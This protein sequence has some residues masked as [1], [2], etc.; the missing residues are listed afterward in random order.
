MAYELLRDCWY[1]ECSSGNGACTPGLARGSVG[2]PCAMFGTLEHGQHKVIKVNGL[3]TSAADHLLLQVTCNAPVVHW[4]K[5]RGDGWVNQTRPRGH[6]RPTY[7]A[8]PLLPMGMHL[9]QAEVSRLGTSMKTL[10]RER[11]NQS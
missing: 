4:K 9:Q 5:R 2:D 3:H 11:R 10:R 7:N 1:G 6:W 8:S